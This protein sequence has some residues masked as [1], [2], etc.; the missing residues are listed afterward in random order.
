MQPMSDLTNQKSR[1]TQDVDGSLLKY[2]AAFVVF[3]IMTLIAIVPFLIA[4]INA[5]GSAA[6]VSVIPRAP[7]PI[8]GTTIGD[9]GSAK[10]S[11]EYRRRYQTPPGRETVGINNLMA[12][13][14][15][16]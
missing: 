11:Y 10:R 9:I 8:S 6:R 1:S 2:V 14:T 3:A 13:K 5:N 4:I 12:E 16:R 7:L 15:S